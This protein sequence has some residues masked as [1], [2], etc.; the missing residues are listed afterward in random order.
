VSL[1]TPARD[2]LLVLG[3]NVDPERSVPL[4]LS[5]LQERFGVCA[6]SRGYRSAAVGVA[7]GASPPFVNLAVRIRTALPPR[8]LREA[9]RRVEERCGR[10]R[11]ADR[12]APRTMDVDLVHVEGVAGRFGRSTLPDPELAV[13]AHLLVPSAE[14][15]SDCR[16]PGQTAPL[17]E[18]AALLP[19]DVRRGL[20]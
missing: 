2:A 10:R 11:S 1:P 12:F 18:L 6:V 4:A 14:V 5:L 13:H 7:P 20:A 16:L 9:C 8:A 3:S 19:A 17:A 15:W